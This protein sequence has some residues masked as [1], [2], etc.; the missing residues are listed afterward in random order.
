MNGP[1]RLAQLACILE[2]MAPKPGNVQ[3]HRDLPGLYLLDFIASALAIGPALDQAAEEGIGRAVEQAIDAT[4]RL[5][6]TNTNLGMVLLLAP[7]AA[8]PS[9][10][11]LATGV[12]QILEAT[13]VEDARAVYRA[14]RLA[15]PGGM[16]S[17][18]E[19]DVAENP[20]LP[21]QEVMRLAADRD[22]IA[23]QYANGFEQVFHDALPALASSLEHGRSVEESIVAIEVADELQV[24]R[25]LMFL[26]LP[27]L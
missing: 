11:I 14:I 23:R 13:T 25:E 9:R 16:G 17:V 1:G 19:Q 24:T 10:S 6:S 18:P 2:V 3:R 22:L 8:V 5:V 4:R 7:L 12:Q 21:L 27:S 20:S 26:V 15:E